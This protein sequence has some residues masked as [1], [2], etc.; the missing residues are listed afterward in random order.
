M[1]PEKAAE[2]L[3]YGSKNGV[4]CDSIVQI[5]VDHRNENSLA[6]ALS[7]IQKNGM[8]RHH[9][10]ILL[11]SAFDLSIG[12]IQILHMWWDRLITDTDLDQDLR[13][14]IRLVANSS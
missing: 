4:P 11:V 9:I 1:T 6:A 12:D 7:E 13:E 8:D 5:R 14:K 2:L 10:R 3:E